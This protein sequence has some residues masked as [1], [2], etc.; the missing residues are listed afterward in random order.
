MENKYK[1]GDWVRANQAE[2]GIVRGEILRVAETARPTGTGPWVM[3]EGKRSDCDDGSYLESRFE[4]WRPKVGERVRVVYG[5]GWDGEG[6]VVGADASSFLVAMN[7]GEY[8]GETGGFRISEI[9]PIIDAPVAEQPAALKIEAGKFYKTRDGRKAGPMRASTRADWPFIANAEGESDAWYMADGTCPYIPHDDL[10]GEWQEPV[11]I[12]AATVDS[13]NDEYGPVVAVVD[14]PKFKVGD[15]VRVVKHC[16]LDGDKI[17]MFAPIG[18]VHTI[19]AMRDVFNYRGVQTFTLSGGGPSFYIPANV[20]LANNTAIVCKIDNGQPLPATRPVVHTSAEA[21]DAEARRLAGIHKGQ[22][23]G[24][25]VLTG[26][27]HKE[28]RVY[29]HE[30]QRLAVGGEKINAIRELRAAS[31]LG[32]ATAKT[33][34]EDW[35]Y[36]EVTAKAA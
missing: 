26:A 3:I 34:V 23:F 27:T 12:T 15:R 13:I 36:R 30:W 35:L 32:L 17:R 24:V 9:E 20:E 19:T 22:E 8:V 14:A 18:S 11:T 2:E 1:K 33:A 5:H 31:G 28:A 16:N 4:P 10:I 21:A 29:E 7:D 25:F 6:D